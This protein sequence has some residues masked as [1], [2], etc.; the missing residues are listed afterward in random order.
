MKKACLFILSFCLLGT[1]AFANS[2]ILLSQDELVSSADAVILGRVASIQCSLDERGNIQTF[3]EVSVQRD[4]L[5]QLPP[6]STAFLKE[7]GGSFDGIA[8]WGFGTAELQVGEDVVLF[9]TLQPDGFFR[10]AHLFQGK[11]GV[12]PSGALRQELPDETGVTH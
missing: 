2:V 1:V 10:I 5:N 12:D 6:G 7:S 4:F 9:A 11:F 8:Q 3:I